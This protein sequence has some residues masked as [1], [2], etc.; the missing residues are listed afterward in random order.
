M[1]TYFVHFADGLW[2]D[3]GMICSVYYSGINKVNCKLKRTKITSGW[4]FTKKYLFLM[5]CVKIAFVCARLSHLSTFVGRR[6]A[7]NY[8][9]RLYNWV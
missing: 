5:F 9:T 2:S 7:V 8:L 3:S 1:S 6:T 4:Q